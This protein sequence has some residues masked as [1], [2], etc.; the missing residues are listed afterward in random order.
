MHPPAPFIRALLIDRPTYLLP[1][2]LGRET[3]TAVL[4]F[5]SHCHCPWHPSWIDSTCLAG[6]C[7]FCF[8]LFFFFVSVPLRSTPPPFFF[9]PLHPI[10]HGRT[11]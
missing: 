7:F 8:F 11:G 1:S 9:L 4:Y 10:K 2:C 3:S 6:I 5:L